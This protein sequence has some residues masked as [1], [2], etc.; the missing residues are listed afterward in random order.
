MCGDK[1]DGIF[2]DA[3]LNVSRFWNILLDM[4]IQ[5]IFLVIYRRP[6]IFAYMISWYNVF[7]NIE[8]QHSAFCWA[9]VA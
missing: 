8:V 7:L 2:L 4:Q 5:Y 6:G 3:W 9:Q 1:C